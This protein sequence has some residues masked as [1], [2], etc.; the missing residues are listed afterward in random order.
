MFLL[1]FRV[2]KLL[3]E[4][5]I[6]LSNAMSAGINIVE[7]DFKINWDY[8][9]S[10]FFSTTILTT[11]GKPTL[12]CNIHVYFNKEILFTE[13]HHIE[14]YWFVFQDMEI[15]PQLQPREGCFASSLLLLACLEMIWILN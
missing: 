4:Y 8:L 14:I 7:Q 6:T 15:L 3:S 2:D 12:S 11:I 9:Q 5:E 10:V 1:C 13:C